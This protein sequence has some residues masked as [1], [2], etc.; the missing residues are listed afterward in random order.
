MGILLKFTNVVRQLG[1]P[2]WFLKSRIETQLSYEKPEVVIC[3][4]N[5]N[6]PRLTS[7]LKMGFL[8]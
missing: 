6:N 5:S 8:A 1:R 3:A 7:A 4:E 2:Y